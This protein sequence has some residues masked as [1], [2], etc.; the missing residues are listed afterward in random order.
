MASERAG[1]FIYLGGHWTT[2]NHPQPVFHPLNYPAWE[3]ENYSAFRS[4]PDDLHVSN[5]LL[6]LALDTMRRQC[7]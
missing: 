6:S 4:L 1:G 5:V 7:R 3:F 2:A